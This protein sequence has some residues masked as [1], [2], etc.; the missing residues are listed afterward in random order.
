MQKSSASLSIPNASTSIPAQSDATAAI[1][2]QIKPF[3]CAV[4]HLPIKRTFD[5]IFSLSALFLGAP[6]FLLI[7]LAI[8]LSSKGAIIYAHERV[9]RGGKLFPCYKFRT[10]YTDADERLKELLVSNTELRDEW[11]TTFKLKNDPRITPIGNFLR[12]TSL[13]EIPQFWNVLKGHLSVVGPRPVIQDEIRLF[14]GQNAHKI[15]SIRP[16]L[17]GLWQTSGRNDTTY[18]ERILLDEEY[19]DKQNFLLDIK[20][21]AKTLPVMLSRKGAY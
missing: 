14:F 13:D 9:G 4:R 12:K 21:V 8:R 2:E 19:I 1:K 11:A 6:V 7:A 17:T 15:L 20:L 5:L 18:E 3:K 16:G 10:M